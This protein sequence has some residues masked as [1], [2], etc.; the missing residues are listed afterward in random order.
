[1]HLSIHR[2]VS[3]GYS[4]KEDTTHFTN[5]SEISFNLYTNKSYTLNQLSAQGNK[6]LHKAL[7]LFNTYL[8]QLMGIS[9]SDMGFVDY[10][11]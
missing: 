2:F 6:K 1:M 11:F 4:G 3:L 7:P 5:S 10:K 8:K 9:M